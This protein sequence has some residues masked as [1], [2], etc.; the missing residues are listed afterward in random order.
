MGDGLAQRGHGGAGGR[1]ELRA[2][3]WAG[4]GRMG[5]LLLGALEFKASH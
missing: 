1:V 2:S 3:S 4:L 5:G